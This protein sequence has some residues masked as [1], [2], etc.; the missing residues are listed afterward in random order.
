VKTTQ[1]REGKS[2]AP[3]R[4]MSQDAIRVRFSEKERVWSRLDRY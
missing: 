3:V 2:N 1:K 4:V